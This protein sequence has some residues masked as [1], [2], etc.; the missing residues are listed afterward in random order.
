MVQRGPSSERWRSGRLL[1]G[2]DEIH[3]AASVG[4]KAPYGVMRNEYVT[5]IV[6]YSLDEANQVLTAKTISRE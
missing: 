2:P 1:G 3:W 5:I 4:T 6:S